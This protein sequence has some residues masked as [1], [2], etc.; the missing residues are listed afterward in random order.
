MNLTFTPMA[1]LPS[2]LKNAPSHTEHFA[3]PMVHPVTGETIS[4][5]K[6]IINDPATAEI[7]QMAFI[8][9]FGGM[10]QGDNK[11]GQKETNAIL[12]MM[13]DEIR[14]VLRQNKKFT[15]GNLV[16]DYRLQ[17]ED[18]NRIQITARGN[19]VT[20]ESSPSVCIGDL[21]TAKLNWNSVC[22]CVNLTY[23]QC[24]TPTPNP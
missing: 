7:W 17:K 6:K 20:Y 15:Y 4:G 14:H 1:L 23:S 18:P 12:V 13:H 19:L 11:T 24:W 21:D 8:K 2:I 16:V 22:V 10:V 5:Y 3:L 9:D